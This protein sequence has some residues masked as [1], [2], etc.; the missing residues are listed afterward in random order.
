MKLEKYPVWVL[1]LILSV[2]MLVSCGSD[3]EPEKPKDDI[4][5]STG[6]GEEPS[7]DKEIPKRTAVLI[8]QFTG[9][10]CAACPYGAQ[11]LNN[12]ISGLAP[13]DQ[14]RIVWVAHH[15]FGDDAF[16]MEQ[17]FEINDAFGVN[18]YPMIVA[19][20][21]VVE[22]SAG[23]SSLIWSPNVATTAL[24]QGMLDEDAG[25]T[26]NMNHTYDP[27]TQMLSVKVSGEIFSKEDKYVTVMVKHSGLVASQNG[28]EG[29]YTHNNVPWLFLTYGRGA[30]V[31]PNAHG[32]YS[33][34]VVQIVPSR[35]GNF[36]ANTEM[37]EVVAFV[38]GDINN[39]GQR[40][41]L[42]AVQA[43]LMK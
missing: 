9:Q 39:A 21:S 31:A 23:E 26:I 25:A 43:P 24:L 40:A 35:L 10:G 13:E 2:F 20:R 22:Y 6:G 32:R 12:A 8:E 30:R 42:N 38:H 16:S 37:M 28:A 36:G 41:V 27:Q 14:S 19:N 33:L 11:I 29:D 18:A 1:A 3:E 34:D 15:T 7:E 4:V 5:D 17:S